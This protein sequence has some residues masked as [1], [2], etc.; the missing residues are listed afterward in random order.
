MFTANQEQAAAEMARV[1]RKG[2]KIGLANWTP[3][4]FIGQI[5]KTLGKYLPPPAVARSPAL[6]GTRDRLDQLFG[7]TAA[8]I[9]VTPRTYV[10]RYRSPE[11][12]VDFFA[13]CYGPML[14]AFA[15]LGADARKGLRE[16]LIALA[17][18]FS[19][20]DDGVMIAPG[21]YIEAVIVKGQ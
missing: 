10:F 17:K 16:D 13:T 11:H 4:G 6:W 7:A 12:F 15:A 2:G 5:F 20:S 9:A 3:D 19:R 14:K 8:S 21:E 18:K 1:C